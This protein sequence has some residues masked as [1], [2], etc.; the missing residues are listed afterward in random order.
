[1]S[2]KLNYIQGVEDVTITYSLKD[3]LQTGLSIAGAVAVFTLFSAVIAKIFGARRKEIFEIIT[4][5]VL[6]KFI[7]IA[8]LFAT[9]Y[10]AISTGTH[11]YSDALVGAPTSHDGLLDIIG[12]VLALILVEGL[13]YR[14]VLRYTK[15]RSF[16]ISAIANLSLLCLL[17][18]SV[19]T[20]R[21]CSFPTI[22]LFP[23]CALCTII[24]ELIVSRILGVKGDHDLA[25]ITFANTLTNPVV[26]F[27]VLMTSERI[28]PEALSWV[29]LIAMEILAVL[30]EGFW[31][32]KALYYE[33]FSG[34]KLS[35][36]NNA[37]SF[38]IGLIITLVLYI[39]T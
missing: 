36:I 39:T 14:L 34:F 23:A 38:A 19:S 9:G 13:A 37:V 6:T 28:S 26:V 25:V 15:F 8:I 22:F 12:I 2:S 4:I 10:L 31:Y 7:T 21:Y 30:V 1:M 20:C 24:I 29:I 35:L 18:F 11:S 3:G 5:N 16:A 27:V 33:R 32:K 17:V